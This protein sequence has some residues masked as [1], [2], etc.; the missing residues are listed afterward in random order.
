MATLLQ[1]VGDLR[2]QLVQVKH[3]VRLSPTE[4]IAHQRARKTK[5]HTDDINQPIKSSHTVRMQFEGMPGNGWIV[6]ATSRACQCRFNGKYNMCPHIIEATKLSG[7]PSP[8]LPD[9]VSQSLTRNNRSRIG[10]QQRYIG[11]SNRTEQR[12]RENT[13][14][15]RRSGD[16]NRIHENLLLSHEARAD[17]PSTTHSSA[18]TSEVTLP[19]SLPTTPYSP[20]SGL[21]V[22]LVPLRARCPPV[23]ALTETLPQT[24]G[25]STDCA[26][27]TATLRPEHAIVLPAPHQHTRVDEMSGYS[28]GGTSTTTRAIAS[29]S[30]S[31]ISTNRESCEDTKRRRY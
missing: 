5:L 23:P 6:D 17:H 15:D 19:T 14:Y 2:N 21:G 7:L 20:A 3:E 1:P 22:D 29:L 13:P 16:E 11:I 28:L 30:T 9:P 26:I 4:I 12:C 8:G 18:T 24:T 25:N 31:R 27:I 10:R